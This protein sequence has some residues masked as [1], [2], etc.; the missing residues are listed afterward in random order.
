ML[1]G[2]IS[3]THGLLRPEALAALQGVDQI[4]HAGDIGGPQIMPALAKAAPISRGNLRP[5]PPAEKRR[6]KRSAL[7]QSR[8]RRPKKI[9][10]AG[11]RRKTGNQE[12]KTNPRINRAATDR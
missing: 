8:K 11:E 12:G 6:D 7:H 10:P 1:L 4:L 5:Q 2:L 3:D 9:Q